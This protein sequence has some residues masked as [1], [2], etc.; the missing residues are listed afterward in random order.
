VIVYLIGARGRLGKAIA[1]EYAGSEFFSLDRSI[2]EDWS[3]TGA[4][5]LVSRYF[6][7]CSNDKAIIFVASGLLDPRL[8]QEGLF[9]VNYLLA[10]N[11]IDGATKLG[12][13]VITFGTVMEG[14]LQSKNPY[15]QSKVKLGDYVRAVAR[16]AK[17]VIHIQLHTLYGRG[18]PSPFMF[19]GQM[20]TAI[21]TNQPFKM[22]SGRQLREYHHLRDE[23]MAVRQVANLASPGVLDLSH[24][25]PLSLKTIAQSVFQNLGKK[26]LLQLGALP[27]PP[28]ENY[29][30][31]LK[32]TQIAQKITFR[33]SLPAITQY[34]QK[35]YFRQEDMV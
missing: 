10:K 5:D 24:G 28:E 6:E 9:R 18:Q 4:V 32:P 35:C 17:P 27:E 13:K 15:I 3:R 11:V 33:D 25:K 34:M 23:A 29:E 19:L 20:L 31:V 1:N 2:Y 22:T 14:R 26:D 7:Q 21:Q 8:S 30:T 12:M 16:E